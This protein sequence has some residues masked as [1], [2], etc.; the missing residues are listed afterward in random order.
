M[1]LQR[2]FL[3]KVRLQRAEMESKSLFK[4]LYP[5]LFVSDEETVEIPPRSVTVDVVGEKAFG[6]LCLPKLWTLPFI[7]ISGNLLS[8]FKKCSNED[9]DELLKSWNIQITAAMP[10]IGLNGE[11][12]II[13]RSSGCT[14]GLIERGKLYS[15]VGAVNTLFQT[16]YTCLQALS[17]DTELNKQTVPLLI[18]KYVIAI[19]AKGHLSN[20]RRVS[21]EKRDWLVQLDDSKT[22]KSNHCPIR[23]RNWR[24]KINSNNFTDKPLACN[25]SARISEVLKV[26]ATWAWEQKPRFHFE[27]VWDGIEIYLVQADQEQKSKGVDPTKIRQLKSKPSSK[28]KP[29]CLK[30]I[31]QEHA[32]RFN[33]IRNVFTYI[34]LGLPFTNLYVL[35]DQAIIKN[36]AL[37]IV[38]Q[39]LAEDI[40]ELVKGSIVIRMDIATEDMRIRQLLPR[41]EE[42]RDCDE[43]VDWIK[44]KSADITNNKLIED[45][46][47]IFHNFVPATASAFAYAAP[48]V[49]KVQIEALWGLP[50]GL[51]YN[52]HD[53]Y[54]VDT[55]ILRIDQIQTADIERFEVVERRHYK[56]FFIAPDKDGHWTSK[57]LK[58]PYDWGNAIQKKAWIKEI[59]FESRRIAE[60]EKKPL[61]IMWF[62]DV[63]N[64][65][66][67]KSIFPWYH[68]DHDPSVT[69]RVGTNRAKTPY[70]KLLVIRT[71]DDL[72]KLRQEA[73]KEHSDVRYVQIQP[74][75]ETLLRNKMTLRDIGEITKKIGAIII[76][77]GGVLSH[78]YYQLM[79]TQAVVEVVHPF[80]DSEDKREFNK[81]VRDKVSSN[82][83]LG[84]EIVNKVQLS[85]EF[86]MRALREKL[87]EEAF[88]VLDAIDKDSIIGELADV[89]ELIDSI[90]SKIDV[91][92][93]VL[94]QRQK[95]KREKAGGFN[96]GVIL[97]DTRN[98]LP[99]KI[100]ADV[101]SPLLDGSVSMDTRKIIELGH[102]VDKWTDKREHSAATEIITRIVVPIVRDNW[103]T[104]NPEK[105][106]GNVTESNI[107]AKIVGTRL[108]SKLQIE[109]SV[110]SPQKQIDLFEGQDNS[111][112]KDTKAPKCPS[113][114]QP[115]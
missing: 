98:P 63:P 28:F 65:Y 46:V 103:T 96:D 43:A 109:L 23:L 83:E 72:Q 59:A 86:L 105:I 110:Y 36:L 35:D 32:R 21:E 33:K 102:K 2:R 29:K 60:E 9:R 18:Q 11:D 17:S 49:R 84:G 108:G 74:C 61:S 93:D 6:L 95:Q 4:P 69:N 1:R 87:V 100:N 111:N 58:P 107:Q 50:E 54:I 13:V 15:E 92:R 42:V 90:L 10:L 30:E 73:Q 94:E 24:E 89:S 112:P 68:E 99:T 56:H 20:E 19:S 27:W 114:N 75:E 62:I 34:K 101:P 104:S 106:S 45:V 40:K 85:G 55:K 31:S 97:L 57:I 3:E 37:G 7:V 14:E 66:C 80:G 53:K 47:F 44:Q 77:E 71:T 51:Y 91:S 8:L 25:L 22:N 26:P 81:L 64:E 70:D 5:V 79:E 67:Q 38:S 115:Q 39:T 76:L 82:I 41:T 16:L 113:Q 12:P 88:E 52:A 78:A 48:G